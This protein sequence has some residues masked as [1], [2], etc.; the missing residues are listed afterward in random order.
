ML[1]LGHSGPLWVQTWTLVELTALMGMRCSG[2]LSVCDFCN[3]QEFFFHGHNVRRFLLPLC[4]SY[5]NWGNHHAIFC[6]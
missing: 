2:A 4:L 6:R 5:N 3:A 1:V